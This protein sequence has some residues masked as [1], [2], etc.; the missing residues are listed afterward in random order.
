MVQL[1]HGVG[2]PGLFGVLV[3]HALASGPLGQAPL[4]PFGLTVGSQLALGL[5]QLSLQRLERRKLATF[6]LQ[7]GKLSS[8]AGA[9][10]TF[11]LA[12]LKPE[13]AADSFVQPGN[14]SRLCH[15]FSILW[16]AWAFG[17]KLKILASSLASM[18]R[19]R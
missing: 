9:V 13:V 7:Y 10:T 11:G 14:C 2:T 17:L 19:A 6:A 4:G 15:A 8:L 1:L 16:C 18:M 3:D 12:H 5:M